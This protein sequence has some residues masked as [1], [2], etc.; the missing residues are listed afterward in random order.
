M[1]LMN[2]LMAENKEAEKNEYITIL[3][4]YDDV[5]AYEESVRDRSF[6]PS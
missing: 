4:S 1:K 3:V 2:K 5:K 6:K